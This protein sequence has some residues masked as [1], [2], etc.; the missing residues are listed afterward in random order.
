MSAVAF[1]APVVASAKNQ[2]L[3]TQE[4]L[5]PSYQQVVNY[6]LKNFPNSQATAKIGSEIFFYKQPTSIATV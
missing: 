2:E 4:N 1:I 6:L 3:T 5:F